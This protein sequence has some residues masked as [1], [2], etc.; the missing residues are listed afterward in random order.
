LLLVL[1]EAVAVESIIQDTQSGSIVNREWALQETLKIQDGF[2]TDLGDDVE[3]GGE[4]EEVDAPAL[5]TRSPAIS[6]QSVSHDSDDAAKDW[7]SMDSQYSFQKAGSIAAAVFLS[8]F[9]ASPV[10][11]VLLVSKMQEENRSGQRGAHPRFEI[12]SLPRRVEDPCGAMDLP[13]PSRS[14]LF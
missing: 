11:T 6:C 1:T 2:V 14:S 7:D 10:M 12:W 8:F 5:R 9:L 13:P 4:L 3:V